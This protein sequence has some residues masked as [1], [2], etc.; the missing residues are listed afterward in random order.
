MYECKKM[1]NS[2]KWIEISKANLIFNI[3]EARKYIGGQVQLSAVVKA[4]AY[5]HGAVEIGGFLEDLSA[6]SCFSVVNVEEAEELR[7]AGVKKP[8]TVLGY[9]TA[10]ECPAIAELDLIPF[11]YSKS[12]LNDLEKAAES[13]GRMLRV[14]VKVETGMGRLGEKGESLLDLLDSI[15]NCRNIE[16]AGFATH[17]SQSDSETREKTLEQLALFRL[18][19]ADHKK[20]ITPP[21][22]SCAA[23]TGGIFLYPDSHFDMV[24][25]GIGLYGFYPSAFV[26]QRCGNTLRP[27]LE[28]K[29]RVVHIQRLKRGESVSYGST[30]KAEKDTDIAVI[31]V[32]YADGYL[33]AFSNV[34]SVVINGHKAPVRGRVCMDLTMVDITGLGD[35][36]TGSEVT[37]ISADP[38]SG[39]SVENLAKFA[40]TINYEI[41]TMLPQHIP[42]VI[43]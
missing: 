15:G 26:K 2:L 16:I 5:G 12:L 1:N 39:C 3:S 19:T 35:V 40:N 9:F 36:E 23:N 18:F 30:W 7:G 38:D 24:R 32:G 33:R 4:N 42:K 8:I 29:T 28:Y 37:L 14:I 17:F 21:E 13:S 25:L 11:I 20:M 31:P 41:T 34:A 6:V 10:Y 43:V 27:I 22:M